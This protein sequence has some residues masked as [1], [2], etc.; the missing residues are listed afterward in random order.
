MNK[1]FTKGPKSWTKSFALV[2][3]LTHQYSVRNQKTKFSTSVEGEEGTADYKVYIHKND[4][5]GEQKEKIHAIRDISWRVSED[6]AKTGIYHYISEIP[7]FTSKKLE[8][9]DG[10][11]Y[12]PI[13]QDVNKDGTLRNFYTDIGF[14]YGCIP[15]TW[16]SP[17]EY[18]LET[19]RT[20]QGD[21][22]PIDV[23]ELSNIPIPVGEVRPVKALGC[24]ALIDEGEVD[25]KIL[26]LDLQTMK[27][28]GIR[29]LKDYE[30]LV[31]SKREPLA[32]V[33]TV[34]N[35]FKYYKTYDGK[36]ANYFAFSDEVQNEA[37]TRDIIAEVHQQWKKK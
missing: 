24:L 8:V 19:D 26:A 37:Y 11:E 9:D 35:W 4:S 13:V 16:E 15:Q 21:N 18:T 25:W 33:D 3:Q 30:E 14:N 5:N 27:Q 12:H 36:P 1:I 28:W 10:A 32:S 17:H 31:R 23:V 2:N 20:L 7:K 29:D 22:D 6:S 34:V